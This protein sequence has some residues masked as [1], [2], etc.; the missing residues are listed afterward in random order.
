MLSKRE[1]HCGGGAGEGLQSMGIY[2]FDQRAH[3]FGE[4]I[5]EGPLVR[6]KISRP[7]QGGFRADASGVEKKHTGEDKKQKPTYARRR[8]P[9]GPLSGEM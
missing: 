7:R 1:Q 4:K 8:R 9:A 3:N 5:G 6:Q 2:S